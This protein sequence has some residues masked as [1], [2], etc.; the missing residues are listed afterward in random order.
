M[1]ERER[2]RKERRGEEKGE[3]ERDTERHRKSRKKL[4]CS[5]KYLYPEMNMEEQ[6][7]DQKSLVCEKKLGERKREKKKKKRE[8]EVDIGRQ[9]KR[10]KT[11]TMLIG[12]Y[13]SRVYF[14][15]FLKKFEIQEIFSD[16][17][18]LPQVL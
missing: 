3:R 17:Y 12:N 16:E 14:L 1:Y 4:I 15:N 10:W 9:R 8:R 2:E 11:L 18:S 5:L 13:W 6:K 7:T